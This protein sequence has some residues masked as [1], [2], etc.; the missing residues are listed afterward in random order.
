MRVIKQNSAYD[1]INQGT[2]VFHAGS[3]IASRW[4]DFQEYS[5]ADQ[6][7]FNQLLP[8][9]ELD[10]TN[11]SELAVDPIPRAPN[12]LEVK[13][14]T[15]VSV[16][17]IPLLDDQEA[18][19]AINTLQSRGYSPE[20]IAE[21]MRHLPIP[22]TKAN[23]RQA[24]RAALDAKIKTEVG[25]ILNEQGLNPQGKELDKKHLNRTNFVVLKSSID[26]HVNNFV[27]KK[28]GE[29]HEFNRAELDSI[30]AQFNQ[31]IAAVKNE[32]FNG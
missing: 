27:G 21:A 30:K 11:S 9:E 29:R 6:E 1:P 26:K 28:S 10:F 12:T 19:Q 16:Q 25:R 13:S 31:L 17:E 18:V 32:V 7:F 24:A 20:D 14:Q 2:V 5:E 3:N 22:T 8:L 23:E 4:E 15:D